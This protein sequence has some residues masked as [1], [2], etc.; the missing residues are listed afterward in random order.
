MVHAAQS[1]HPGGSLSAVEYLL[2]LYKKELDISPESPSDPD[3][4]R[5]V[6]SKGHACPVLYAI[7]AHQGFIDGDPDEEF[8]RLKGLATGPRLTE[9]PW[10]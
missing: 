10:C 1:G 9:G 5:L 3:R 8:R 6:Y 4:D 2:W 7:L